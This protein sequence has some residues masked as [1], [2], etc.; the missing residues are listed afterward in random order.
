MFRI[1]PHR[2]GKIFED[3][4]TMFQK[5]QGDVAGSISKPDEGN[6]PG[7]IPQTTGSPKI[8][9]LKSL[10][11]SEIQKANQ[12]GDKETAHAFA[13]C[14]RALMSSRWIKEGEEIEVQ[15]IME[16]EGL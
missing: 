3:K 4:D 12:F 9:K 13:D 11:R 5:P 14:L 10:L 6:T 15:D 8:Q 1:T 16:I 2:H 7:K